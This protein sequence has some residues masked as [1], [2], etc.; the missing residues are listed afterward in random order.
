MKSISQLPIRGQQLQVAAPI[1]GAD[2]IIVFQNGVAVEATVGDLPAPAS[3]ILTQEIVDQIFN[4][5]LSISPVPNF[6][7]VDVAGNA[8]EYSRGNFSISNSSGSNMSMFDDGT[9]KISAANGSGL[10]FSPVGKGK[11]DL[12]PDCSGATGT[13]TSADG[14]TVTVTSGIITSIV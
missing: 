10:G 1:T 5:C 9:F 6:A 14:K 7:L 13:F 4:W 12:I 11:F 3:F 8:I 2:A